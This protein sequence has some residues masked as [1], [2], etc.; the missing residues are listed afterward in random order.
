MPKKSKLGSRK[1]KPSHPARSLKPPKIAAK[2]HANGKLPAKLS[3][4]ARKAIDLAIKK[5]AVVA[6]GK[7]GKHHLP[8][9]AS[10]HSHKDDSAASKLDR[11]TKNE[12]IK[13]L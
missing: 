5:T 10:L 1:T 2:A 12:K 4:K 7:K 13:E 3:D 9:L 6:K 11:V 8:I